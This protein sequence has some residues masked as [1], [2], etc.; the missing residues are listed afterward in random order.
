M[1]VSHPGIVSGMKEE[2]SL[3]SKTTEIASYL[4]YHTTNLHGK[5]TERIRQ[6]LD[7]S[8]GGAY[9]HV[10]RGTLTDMNEG[11]LA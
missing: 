11:N 2:G 1:I 4:R 6:L 8:H 9:I 5:M 10:A 3:H 7:I